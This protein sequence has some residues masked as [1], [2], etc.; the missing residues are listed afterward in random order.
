MTD[1]PFVTHRS[2]LFTVAYEM[3]GTRIDIGGASTVV[4]VVV[5][6]GRITRIYAIRNPHKLGWLDKV[7]ELRR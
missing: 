1:D 6:D 3:L 7:A 5:E 4:S 2:L